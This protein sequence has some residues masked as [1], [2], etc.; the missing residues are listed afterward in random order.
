MKANDSD[1]WTAALLECYVEIHLFLFCPLS[2]SGIGAN[3]QCSTLN[4]N[5]SNRNAPAQRS[6]GGSPVY[7]ARE[8][9]PASGV[10]GTKSTQQVQRLISSAKLV[11]S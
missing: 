4:V 1:T 6:P 7:S 8:W 10:G 2:C 3:G 11:P 9:L 5:L